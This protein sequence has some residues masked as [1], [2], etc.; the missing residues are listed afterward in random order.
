[1]ANRKMKIKLSELKEKLRAAGAEYPEAEA[2]M[3]LDVLSP[4]FVSTP[5]VEADVDEKKLKD[6]LKGRAEGQPIQYLLGVAWFYNECYEVSPA[7]LIPRSD[8][9]HLVEYA[10]RHLPKNAHFLDMC[11]GSGCVAISILANRPDCTAVAIDNSPAALEIAKR[12]AKRNGVADRITFLLED[13]LSYL[14]KQPFNGFFSN[15]PYIEKKVIPTLSREVQKEPLSALDGG[16]DGLNFY[17]YFCSHLSYYIYKE[18]ICALEIGYDQ[19]EA[20]SALARKNNL[21]LTIAKDFG[22]CDRLAI[23]SL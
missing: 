7:C 2:K 14:P 21:S 8:T 19:G 22:G 5:F 17:R 20:L 6:I 10:I 11:T 13:G 23:L 18:G 1:M 9:E 4:S 12:N 3:V 16:E 15:P